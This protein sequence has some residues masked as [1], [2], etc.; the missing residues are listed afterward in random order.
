VT[1]EL[2]NRP[3]ASLRSGGGLHGFEDEE[4][5]G[6]N[7][8]PLPLTKQLIHRGFVDGRKRVRFHLL[9]GHPG[10]VFDA[11]TAELIVEQLALVE[12]HVH[13]VLLV[14]MVDERN[15][16]TDCDPNTETF[17][18]FAREG[19]A[20]RLSALDSTSGKVPKQR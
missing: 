1:V 13:G 15:E 16:L 8:V 6:R 3:G 9:G 7:S 10:V 11:D 17:L 19:L 20:I 12:I 4:I 5:D 18:H 2:A 14:G